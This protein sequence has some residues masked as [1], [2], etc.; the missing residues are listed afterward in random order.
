MLRL[1]TLL[2]LVSITPLLSSCSTHVHI[3]AENIGVPGQQNDSNISMFECARDPV[4][5][6][7]E[8]SGFRRIQGHILE[9]KDGREMARYRQIG[10]SGGEIFQ[11][12]D[13]RPIFI[14]IEKQ[15]NTN[16]Y[17]AYYAWANDGLEKAKWIQILGKFVPTRFDYR[18]PPNPQ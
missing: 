13:T 6:E 17:Y 12:V 7:C 8:T 15:K 14:K 16:Y 2:S 9:L 10:T 3:A 4:H 11:G 18:A 5:R 1:F